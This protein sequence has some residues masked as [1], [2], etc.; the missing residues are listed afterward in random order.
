MTEDR[1]HLLVCF[2]GYLDILKVLV[3]AGANIHENN[4][5]GTTPIMF[6]SMFGNYEIVKY[7]K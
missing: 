2:K 3:N 6:A 1:H 7:L 4:G 5:L